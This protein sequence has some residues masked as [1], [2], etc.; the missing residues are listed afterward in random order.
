MNFD[1]NFLPSDRIN[2]EILNFLGDDDSNFDEMDNLLNDESA[3][4]SASTTNQEMN[5]GNEKDLRDKSE[6]IRN[7]TM[8]A[9]INN[10]TATSTTTAPV[11]AKIKRQ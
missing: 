9:D 2:N 11:D 7:T 10:A 4:T 1:F 6:R 8:S 3:N 5:N